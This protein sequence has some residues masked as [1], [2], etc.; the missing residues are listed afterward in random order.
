MEN[1]KNEQVNNKEGEKKKKIR[2]GKENMR[3]RKP[4]QE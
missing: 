2:K 3:A 1:T 4:K